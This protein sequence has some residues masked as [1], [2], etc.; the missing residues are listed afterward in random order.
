M[1][2]F[3]LQ[4]R[5]TLEEGGRV[6]LFAVFST[7]VWLIWIIKVVLSRRY[8]PWTAPHVTTASV[9]I[10]VVD[11]PVDL[12]R[13]VLA[14]IVE[15]NPHETIVIINGPANPALEHVCQQFP[16]VAWA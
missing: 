1:F 15:Q 4:V 7:I 11:E 16:A 10:P 6:Y 2:V 12:F 3:L 13:E 5:H 14:R 8:R 9:V